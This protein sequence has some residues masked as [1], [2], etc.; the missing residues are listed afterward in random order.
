M[1]NYEIE[2]NAEFLIG[3]VQEVSHPTDLTLAFNI[4]IPRHCELSFDLDVTSNIQAWDEIMLLIIVDRGD[5]S[6]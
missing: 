5:K 3:R 6:W 2:I 1:L 4:N